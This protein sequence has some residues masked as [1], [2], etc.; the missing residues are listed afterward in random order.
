MLV[1]TV[2]VGGV[3]TIIGLVVLFVIVL[4]AFGHWVGQ[5]GILGWWM[6]NQMFE[7]LGVILQA[8][9]ACIAAMLDNSNS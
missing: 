2:T 7:L 6:A 8:I 9:F 1:A 5:G 4:A 3:L